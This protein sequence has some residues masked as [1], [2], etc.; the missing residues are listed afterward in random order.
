MD[1][2]GRETVPCSICGE[3]TANTGTKKCDGCWEVT[4]RLADFLRTPGGR[5]FVR[6]ALADANGEAGS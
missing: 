3:P 4:H 1:R 6:Q 5:A 2:F